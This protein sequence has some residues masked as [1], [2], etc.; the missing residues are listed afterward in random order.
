M[1]TSFSEYVHDPSTNR[2]IKTISFGNMRD[3]NCKKLATNIDTIDDSSTIIMLRLQ[4]NFRIV[5]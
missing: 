2:S 1:I 5:L 4:I 3:S